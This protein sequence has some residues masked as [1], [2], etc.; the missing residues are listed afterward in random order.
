MKF[1]INK[2]SNIIKYNLSE[3]IKAVKKDTYENPQFEFDSNYTMIMFFNYFIDLAE[4][5]DK[6]QDVKLLKDFIQEQVDALPSTYEGVLEK[7]LDLLE[8]DED[9]EKMFKSSSVE[10]ITSFFYHPFSSFIYDE[11][12]LFYDKSPVI[13]ALK[14]K[15]KTDNFSQLTYE[16]NLDLSKHIKNKIGHAKYENILTDEEIA[17]YEK[18]KLSENKIKDL[19]PKDINEAVGFLVEM[20]EENESLNKVEINSEETTEVYTSMLFFHLYDYMFFSFKLYSEDAPL[21]KY[22]K[23]KKN[24]DDPYQM[25]Y[26]TIKTFVNYVKL[27]KSI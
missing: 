2:D 16:L 20:F 5:A 8:Y 25:I 11:L 7:C 19:L 1:N 13:K 18:N 6:K 23:E 12:F 17:L 21:V 9:L 26:N 15:F 4:S 27:K 24:I 22:F 10:V 14:D 3:V